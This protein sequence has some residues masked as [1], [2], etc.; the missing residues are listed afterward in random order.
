MDIFASFATDESKEEDGIVVFLTSGQDTA[1]DPWIRVARMGNIEYS[2]A[3]TKTYE[4][5][6]ADKKALRLSD[7]EME[8]RSKNAMTEVLAKTILKGF[9]NLE[10]QGTPLVPGDAANLQLMRVKDFSNLV[11]T[12]ASN[13]ELYR[14]EQAQA[15]TGNSQPA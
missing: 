2:K 7:A 6:Q 8:I 4:K 1:T 12:N 14:I 5:L 9:G 10:F 11:V 3:V 15:D 13:V